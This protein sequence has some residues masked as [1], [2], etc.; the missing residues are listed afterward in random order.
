MATLNPIDLI[1][2]YIT[3]TAHSRYGSAD[4]R[5]RLYGAWIIGGKLC[6]LSLFFPSLSH[7]ELNIRALHAMFR[8]K[9]AINM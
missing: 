5:D 4:Y 8:Y 1:S 2:D 6:F 3:L 7:T 9:A